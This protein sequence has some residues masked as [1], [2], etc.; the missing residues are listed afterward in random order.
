MKPSLPKLTRMIRRPILLI[1]ALAAAVLA[2]R[3]RPIRPPERT[4][5]WEPV[6]LER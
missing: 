5:T 2:F 6:E 1:A 4:G 3:K